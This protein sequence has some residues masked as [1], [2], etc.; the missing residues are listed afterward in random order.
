MIAHYWLGVSLQVGVGVVVSLLTRTNQLLHLFATANCN[1]RFPFIENCVFPFL[2]LLQRV[3][4][5]SS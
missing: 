1:P 2:H 4:V 3:L 5:N